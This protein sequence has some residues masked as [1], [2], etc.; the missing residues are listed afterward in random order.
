[1]Q[2]SG[3]SSMQPVPWFL[4]TIPSSSP[5][6]LSRKAVGHGLDAH[7]AGKRAVLVAAPSGFGKTVAVAQWA[8]ERQSDHLGSVAWLTL[9]ER[10]NDRT[11]VLRG[12]LTALLNSAREAGDSSLDQSLSR[13]FESATYD[14]AVAVLMTIDPRRNVT[15]VIDDFQFARS[16][17]GDEEVVEL[18]ENGPQWLRFVLITTDPVSP[19]W[20]RLRVHDKVAV[21]GSAELAFTRD[22]V[23]ALVEQRGA[24]AQPEDIDHIM[25]ASGGWPGAVR[26]ILVSGDETTSFSDDVDLTDYIG[27]AVL[28]RLRPDL[29]DFALKATVC[30]R[31]D[32]QLARALTDR[33][34]SGE[35]LNDCV[36]AGLFLERIGSGESTIFQW[37][38]I[39]VKHCQE[40]LKRR[41][42]EEWTRL[43]RLAAVKLAQQYP[44]E[45][46]ELAI[47][48]GDHFGYDVVAEHWLE[49]LMQS[50]SG[51]LDL[52]CVRLAEAFGENAETLMIR[53]SCRAMVGDDVA[54]ALLFNRAAR[55]SQS[56]EAPGRL[57]LIADL[58]QLLI[59]DDREVMD[60]AAGRVEVALSD[61]E[62]VAPRIYACA[63]FVLGWADSRLRRSP[64]RG[65]EYLEA[66]V[67]ECAALG[68]SEVAHRARQSLAFALAHSGELGRAQQA[69]SL[70]VSSGESSPELWLS[71]DGDGIQR[72]TAG[73]IH[74]WHGEITEAVEDFIPS[75]G[76][77]GVGYPDTSRMFLAFSA[78]TLRDNGVVAVA[79]AAVARMPDADTHGVPWINYKTGSRARLAE[80]RGEHRL[81]LELAAGIV[82]AVHLPMVSAVLSGMC[83]RLGAPELAGRLARQALEPQLPGYIAAYAQYTLALL[84][85]QDGQPEQAHKRMEEM[86]AAARPEHVRYQFVDNPD[87]ACQE[88]LAAHRSYTAYPDFVEQ[89]LLASEHRRADSGAAGLTPRERE[90]LAFLRTPMTM[91]EIADKMSISV[92][93]LKT[94]QRAI[95]R[96]LGATNR[97]EAI[98]RA[99]R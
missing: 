81:A 27:T 29:A 16:V 38:S 61:R 19:S 6:M 91:Q 10:V 79:E 35:L 24:A 30:P 86:L 7:L 68:L 51:A 72:F 36:A 85:W 33:P 65:S 98:N 9:T 70:A 69:L 32:E 96:K 43:N 1:M 67:H 59:S 39:F 82:G 31:V 71:H 89:A 63:L 77:V 93:T 37:H 87:S 28:A 92:N 34:D 83:R 50:R 88:L 58:T 21:I 20:A 4:A 5:G 76:T 8:A 84:A 97:R 53:S 17:W 62:L 90:I 3:T 44:L 2:P 14:A 18:V 99:A 66:A 94:H 45:A 95:Y 23:R 26:L 52:A 78:A 12:V 55:M 41:H 49:L 54:A 13:A 11:D 73:W 48:G 64:T 42:P 47:R 75:S 25:T 15:I 22:E 40:I 60:R 74:F 46:V 57:D 80:A 56:G